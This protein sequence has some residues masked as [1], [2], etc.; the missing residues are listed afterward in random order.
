MPATITQPPASAANQ[1]TKRQAP[2]YLVPFTRAAKEHIEP[3]N[4]DTR[5][6]GASSISVGPVDVAAYGFARG[7][8]IQVDAT[9]GT[10]T[11]AVAAEDGPWSVIDEIQLID[12]NGAPLWLGSGYDLYLANKYGGY[13]YYND[14]KN[15]PTT[16]SAISGT[17]GNFRWLLRI[18][19]EINPRDGLGSLPNQNA[20]SSYKI[21]YTI[22]PSTKVYS[23]PPATTLPTVRVRAHL[24][25]WSQPTQTDLRGNTNATAPPAVGTTMFH[26][27]TI[28]NLPSGFQNVKLSRMGN[29]IRSLIFINRDTNGSRSTGA[30]LFPDPSVLYW[31]TR[32]L[33]NAP[34]DLWRSLMV[35][36]TGYTAAAE[37]PNGLDNGVFVMDF[38][39]DFDGAIGFELRDGWIGTAQSTR[40]ELSGT[41]GGAS[42]LTAITCDVSPAGEIYT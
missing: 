6:L 13:F 32:P 39:H 18:P 2:A 27:K 19:V 10:G 29:Y 42:V 36:R 30:T 24:D 38:A 8:Y 22:A 35:R 34:R 37:Q 1:D 16:F 40:M 23:T 26:S 15:D 12:V 3:F 11:G 20:A 7:I 25:A 9:G 14:P 17:G 41:W 21:K 33:Q 31:D 5:Q 28:F 4:D